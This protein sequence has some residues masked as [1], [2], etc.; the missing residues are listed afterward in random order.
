VELERAG[1]PVAFLS[2]VPAI[3]LSLG[4]ARVVLGVAIPH[5]LGDPAATAEREREIRRALLGTALEAL[6]QPV[7]A[8][9][10]FRADLGSRRPTTP[11]SG[12]TE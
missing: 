11:A 10:L 7:S 2:A 5:V 1:I 12:V 9:T 6:Q 8:P 3:P 4:V